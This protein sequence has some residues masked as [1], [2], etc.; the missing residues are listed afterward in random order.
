MTP[1]ITEALKNTRPLG[2]V[3]WL[4]WNWSHTPLIA[5]KAQFMVAICT[6]DDQKQATIWAVKVRRGG[7]FM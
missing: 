5:P 4:G 1:Q 6:R 2:Q 7:I 3:K